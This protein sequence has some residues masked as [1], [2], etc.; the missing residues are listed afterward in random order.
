MSLP[1]GVDSSSFASRLVLTLALFVSTTG[2]SPRTVTSSVTEPTFM[3]KSIVVVCVCTT[4]T[5]SRVIVWN[6]GSATFSV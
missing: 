3:T 6:P 5:F 4:T 1:P 2:V